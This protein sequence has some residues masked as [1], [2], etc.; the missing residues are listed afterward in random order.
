MIAIEH[1]GIYAKL[2]KYHSKKVKETKKLQ[3]SGPANLHAHIIIQRRFLYTGMRPCRHLQGV[4]SYKFTV[5][6]PLNMKASVQICRRIVATQKIKKTLKL[7]KSGPTNLH[8]QI[9]IQ[10]RFLY[11]CM[12]PCR[13]LQGAQSCKFTV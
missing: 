2:Q 8:V 4:Q 5:G 3:K 1:E 11:T 9:I 6:S 7:Q 12:R 13:H 10:R